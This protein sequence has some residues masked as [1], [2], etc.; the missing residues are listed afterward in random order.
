MQSVNYVFPA[1]GGHGGHGGHGGLE[2]HSTHFLLHYM[3]IIIIHTV[4]HS[5]KDVT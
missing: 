3:F 5:S 4:Y 1:L 2:Q